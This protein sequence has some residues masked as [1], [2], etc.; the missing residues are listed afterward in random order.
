MKTLQQD[1]KFHTR[2]VQGQMDYQV[3]S[4]AKMMKLLSDNLYSDKVRAVIRELSTNALDGHVKAGTQDRPFDVHLPTRADCTFR[5]R[6]YGSGMS[7]EQLERMYRTYGASDKTDSND[8]QGCMGLGSKSPFAYTRMFTTTS[9]YNGRKY[10]YVNAKDDEDVPTLNRMLVEDTNEPNGIEVSFAVHEHNIAEFAE[11]ASQVYRDFPVTPNIKGNVAS[12]VIPRHEFSYESKNGWRLIKQQ[13]YGDKTSFAIM[14]YVRYPITASELKSDKDRNTPDNETVVHW[15]R[16]R[17][18]R[19][20][21]QNKYIALLNMGLEIDFCIGDI[22]MDIS[23]EGLQYTKLTKAAIKNRLDQVLAELKD[24]IES[25]FK[26]CDHLYEARCLYDELMNGE[27]SHIQ[28]L[29]SMVQT[30]FRGI[31]LR[32]KPKIDDFD[33]TVFEKN[34]NGNVSRSTYCYEI[35]TDRNIK[36]YVNDMARGAYAACGRVIMAG[37]TSRV[38]LIKED[39]KADFQK[40]LGMTDAYFINCSSLPKPPKVKRGPQAR[41]FKFD[42]DSVCVHDH[43]DAWKNDEVDMDDGGYYV[44][45]ANWKIDDDYMETPHN[46]KEMINTLKEIGIKV[47]KI[48][49]VKRAATKKFEDHDDWKT[50]SSWLKDKFDA[51]L[52]TAK[53]EDLAMQVSAYRK[54]SGQGTMFVKAFEAKKG[55]FTAD[56]RMRKFIE[57]VIKYR[58]IAE[59]NEEKVQKVMDIARTLGHSIDS[60]ANDKLQG[61]YDACKR[62]YPMLN[63]VELNSLRYEKKLVPIIVDYCNLVDANKVGETE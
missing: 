55:D 4:N 21:E 12:F 39:Q 41:V 54:L 63:H 9:Y 19:G 6:D 14:G 15:H 17:R 13:R 8:Y 47:P 53:L 3:A 18:G 16:N 31:D 26:N 34:Y 1:A 46:L 25:R 58:T 59:K 44:T 29:A 57:N 40:A 32:Q 42:I 20:T 22:E 43:K 23:R 48:I 49:G 50:L 35:P 62:E 7:P 36:I 33:I 5:L 45:I 24:W 51:Y 38:Y 60:G 37:T 27:F 30:E 28:D 61:E 2:G 11:K 56:G 10:V 52:K